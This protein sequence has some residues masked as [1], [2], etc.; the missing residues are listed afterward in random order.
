MTTTVAVTPDK[1]MQIITGG[2]ASA[3]LGA[4]VEF[5]FGHVFP[6]FVRPGA[7]S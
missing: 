7:G 3:I 6:L 1:V 2:W 5:Q 4:A